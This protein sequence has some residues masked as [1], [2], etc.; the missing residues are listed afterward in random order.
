VI[1][2]CPGGV[3]VDEG[4]VGDVN[5]IGNI[6]QEFVDFGGVFSGDGAACAQVDD[7]GKDE[8]DDQ[9]VVESVHPQVLAAANSWEGKKEDQEDAAK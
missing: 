6:A 8:N 9:G 7:E 5:G 4:I 1:V 2:G 3:D